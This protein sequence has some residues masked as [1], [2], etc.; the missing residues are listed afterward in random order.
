MVNSAPAEQRD[1]VGYADSP[2]DFVWPNGARMALNIVI[3]YEEGAER[4]SL[5][6][7]TEVDSGVYIGGT[8]W[9]EPP[10]RS[11]A[12]GQRDFIAEAQFEYGSRVGIWRILDVLED[13]DFPYTVFAC[14]RAL[15]RNPE[16]AEA[17]AGGNCDIIGHGYRWIS[18]SRLSK[19]E[20]RDQIRAAKAS[21]LRTTGAAIDG[22]FNRPPQ[23]EVTRDVLAEEGFLYDSGSSSDELPYFSSIK[24]RPFLVVPYRNDANDIRWRSTAQEFAQR[25]IDSFDA[26]FLESR[27]RPRMMQLGLHPRMIGQPGNIRGLKEFLSHIPQSEVWI[28]PRTEIA[29]FWAETYG[30]PDMWNGNA[31]RA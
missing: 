30:T 22:W 13:F 21:I 11:R 16:V 31:A 17:F 23:T 26:R 25:T 6:G 28:T 3:N 14:A 7:D 1:F 18:H 12:V 2:P 20:E 15:E 29:H 8:T 10:D 27:R 5:D 4:N 9:T 24:G 19:E